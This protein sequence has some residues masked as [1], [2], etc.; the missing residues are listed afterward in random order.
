MS[1]IENCQSVTTAQYLENFFRFIAALR[2]HVNSVYQV[3]WFF[4]DDYRESTA[5]LVLNLY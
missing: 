3:N 4:F 1:N 2:G 5:G